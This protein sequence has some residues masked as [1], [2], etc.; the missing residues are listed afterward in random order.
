MADSANDAAGNEPTVTC[1]HVTENI[2]KRSELLLTFTHKHKDLI[3]LIS[4]V[5]IS[6]RLTSM[7]L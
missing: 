2:R 1:D 6:Y 7:S 3:Y 5:A 4:L